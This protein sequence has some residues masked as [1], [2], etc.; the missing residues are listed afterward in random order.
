MHVPEILR[1]LEPS[2]RPFGTPIIGCFAYHGLTPM[3]TFCR[4]YQDYEQ[5]NCESLA[6]HPNS[7]VQVE[8]FY[9]A[10]DLVFLIESEASLL[11]ASKS[12]LETPSRR[13]S[14][15]LSQASL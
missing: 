11:R 12:A 10:P 2:C 4:P 14:G 15:K 3:A 6:F 1:H 7:I 9:L 13:A 8:N 5:P